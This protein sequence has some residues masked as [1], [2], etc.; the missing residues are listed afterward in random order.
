M[1]RNALRLATALAGVLAFPVAPAGSQA[2]GLP[3]VAD[4]SAGPAVTRRIEGRARDEQERPVAG[5]RVLV[6]GEGGERIERTTDRRGRFRTGELAPGLWRV[7]ID[8]GET[9]HGEGWIRIPRPQPAPAAEFTIFEP[10]PQL[11]ETEIALPPLE[12]LGFP[13]R[14]GDE[15]GPGR[16]SI[17]LSR[18]PDGALPAAILARLTAGSRAPGAGDLPVDLTR[19]RFGVVV[20]DGLPAGQEHGLLVWISPTPFGGLRDDALTAELAARGLIWIGAHDAGNPRLPLERHAL[21][22]AAVAGARERWRIDPGRIYVAGYSGGGR[23]ASQLAMLWSEVFRGGLFVMG[24]NWYERLAVSG[25]P[26]AHWDPPFASPPA[27]DL[28]HLRREGRFVLLTGERDFNR[29]QTR[30]TRDAAARAGFERLLYLEVPDL[31]HYGRVPLEFWRR[32]LEFLESSGRTVPVG[33]G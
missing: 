11:P 16:S 25:R 18:L 17:R 10:L 27:S 4:E 26:G 24:C 23:I 9:G 8:A 15:A 13:L 6:L 21:A 31:D 22:L 12:E 30:A 1:S 14:Q 7:E 32:A 3:S 29:D 33:G 20:P 19:E 5:A 28:R 2:G